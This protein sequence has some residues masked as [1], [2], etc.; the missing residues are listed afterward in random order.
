MNKY[1]IYISI[2]LIWNSIF[3][4]YFIKIQKYIEK[5]GELKKFTVECSEINGGN[6]MNIERIFK[7][8]DQ[9]VKILENEIEKIKSGDVKI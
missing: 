5:L 1:D 4:G 9:K 7:S 8:L 6:F 2:L 3:T